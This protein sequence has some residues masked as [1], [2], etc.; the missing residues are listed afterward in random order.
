MSPALVAVLVGLGYA[1]VLILGLSLCAAAARGDRMGRRIDQTL[2]GDP[3]P[4]RLAELQPGLRAVMRD[5]PTPHG[6]RH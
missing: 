1:L 6:R 2:G 5:D 4:A 3:E